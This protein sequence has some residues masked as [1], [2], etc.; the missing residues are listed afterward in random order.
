[1]ANPS[2]ASALRFIEKHL[3]DELSPVAT[4]RWMIHESAATESSSDSS[5]TI[6]GSPAAP[7]EFSEFE[8]KPEIIDLSTPRFVDL[9]SSP[10]EFDSEVSLSDFDFKPSYQ[11]GNQ[12]EPEI[13]TQSNRKPPLKISVPTKTEWIQFDP[14]PE[15]TKPKQAIAEEK[16]HYRGVRQRPW[17][18]F[19]AEI[20]DPN[21]RGSRIWLGT[22]DTAIEAARAYDQAAFR[23]RGSKAILNFPLEVGKWKTRSNADGEKKRKRHDE[24][25][26]VTVVEKVLKTE[27]NVNGKETFPFVESDLTELYDWD[28]TGFLNFPLLSPLSPRPS[29]SYSEL[30]VA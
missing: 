7:I 11:T 16:K 22:F 13:K 10:F 27:Q 9:I 28:L 3:L 12:F 15:V 6:F 23:L 19:A 29:F 25:E 8:N 24:L 26:D 21:K 17:G 18:K 1:M 4:D 20:R 2:E 30:T 5:P 14:Q